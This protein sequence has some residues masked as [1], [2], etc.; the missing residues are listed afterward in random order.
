MA[1]TS[2]TARAF[3][4]SGSAKYTPGA[5]SQTVTPAARYRA[6]YR[7]VFDS[8]LDEPAVVYK[9]LESNKGSYPWYGSTYRLGNGFDATA[10]VQ[11]IDV[12][13]VDGSDRMADVHYTY[14][15][16]NAQPDFDVQPGTGGAMSANPVDWLDD[17]EVSYTQSLVPVEFAFFHGFT[18]ALTGQ[19]TNG[20]MV[21]GKVLPVTNSACI[22]FDP[23]LEDEEQIKVIRISRNVFE[24]DGPF[25]DGWQGAV[26]NDRFTISKSFYRYEE[27]FAPGTALCKMIGGIF[28][29]INGIKHWRQ[30]IEIWK[31]LSGWRRRIQDRGM[32]PRR[33]AGDPDGSGGTISN[34]D[35]T[36]RSGKTNHAVNKDDASYPLS[37]PVLF[38]GKGQPL[39]ESYPPVYGEWQTKPEVAFAPLAGRAW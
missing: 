25:F 19:V 3:G 1:I 30:T 16:A 28:R 33:E 4:G 37:E 26:N 10:T 5:G 20:K 13:I 38:D 39:R 36:G 32:S 11:G 21:P 9:F 2:F 18:S 27:T 14:E 6:T 29:H 12:E 23:P 35:L 15:P 17:V 24:Y 34:S 7:A 22:P 31:K 8:A